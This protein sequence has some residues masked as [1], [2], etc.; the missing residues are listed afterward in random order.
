[1][2]F[3]GLTLLQKF[4]KKKEKEKEEVS[5]MVLVFFVYAKEGNFEDGRR[6]DS[7]ERITKICEFNN[8]SS[9]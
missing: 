5:L 2:K 3:H 7:S 6:F 9:S 8:L 1:M 4:E